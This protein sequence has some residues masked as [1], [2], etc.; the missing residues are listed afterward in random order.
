[1]ASKAFEQFQRYG[2][3]NRIIMRP[4]LKSWLFLLLGG[5]FLIGSSL[6]CVAKD[7]LYYQAIGIFGLVFFGF[8]FLLYANLLFRSAQRGTLVFFQ[9]GIYYGLYGVD[10]AWPDIGPAW[11]YEVKVRGKTYGN[12]LFILRRASYYKAKLGA[13]G[14]LLFALMQWQA[15]SKPGM[16]ET[17]IFA[18]GKLL[19]NDVDVSDAFREMRNR[20]IN[21]HDATVLWV[22]KIMRFE[23]SNDEVVEIINT[24]VA[25]DAKSR[26]STF[27]DA[28]P[29]LS[30]PN[31]FG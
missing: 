11:V 27:N 15:R 25:R 4:S 10:L 1:M 16:I 20:V 8:C 31:T 14:S 19:S 2:L 22:P 17:G 30:W 28:H 7:S 29:Q 5:P 21:E 6:V 26:L 9:E 13:V 24:I 3:D 18:F 23:L 12:V